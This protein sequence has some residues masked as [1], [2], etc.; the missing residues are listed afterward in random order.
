MSNTLSRKQI[1]Q[2]RRLSNA[3]FPMLGVVVV[4][5]LF[6]VRV[7]IIQ[8]WE[9]HADAR[10]FQQ[11]KAVSIN[12]PTLSEVEAPE[13]E[14][15][16]TADEQPV[17][18]PDESLTQTE[19]SDQ[20]VFST[21]K[22]FDLLT[23]FQ[24]REQNDGFPQNDTS[25]VPP[26]QPPVE[27]LVESPPVE[28][29]LIESPSV[30]APP[31][32]TSTSDDNESE[33]PET[34]HVSQTEPATDPDP[35]YADEIDDRVLRLHNPEGNGGVVYFVVDEKTYSIE[36]GRT[37]ELSGKD[38]W[39]LMFHRGGKFG[40]SRATLKPGSYAFAV[41]KQGWRLRVGD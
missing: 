16:A 2:M 40:N 29:P 3:R 23:Q 34:S 14:E 37:L 39:R 7:P 5:A 21:N 17:S 35:A 30:E 1:K 27:S 36:V 32:E 33:D 9:T 26:T 4:A 18:Q 22:W 12:R 28:A 38:E 41:T 20:S 10:N 11:L 31:V 6:V 25:Q 24:P 19:D 13:G 8:S 15:V